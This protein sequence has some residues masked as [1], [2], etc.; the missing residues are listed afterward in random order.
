MSAFQDEF[1]SA[2]QREVSSEDLVE[3]IVRHKSYGLSQVEAYCTLANLHHDLGCDEDDDLPVCEPLEDVMDRIWGF[4][5]ESEKIWDEIL[6]DEE[7]R[8]YRTR[9]R[10][11]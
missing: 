11:E 3:I 2:V 4:C 5:E 9:E 1:Q 8:E 6:S 7:V 10:Q